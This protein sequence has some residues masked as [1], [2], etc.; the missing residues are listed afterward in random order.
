MRRCINKLV[1][2]DRDI[3]L[4]GHG[5]GGDLD[6]LN[7]LGFDLE[8]SIIG[9]LDTANITYELE[10]DRSLL[11]QL[12]GELECPKSSARLHNAGKDANFTL[13]A[14]ILL[15]IKGYGDW[16]LNTM[17]VE[18]EIIS[19]IETLRA[20]AMSPLPGVKKPK[21]KRPRKK[22]IAKQWSLEKREEIREERRQRRIVSAASESLLFLSVAAEYESAVQ[23]AQ[24]RQL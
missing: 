22:E 24:E 7:S 13:R 14:L 6:A 19:R 4:V 16:N 8:T 11:G 3:V 15:A 17:N 18:K 5:F 9:I 10:M 21:K 12:L 1:P 2:R 20:V 23:R